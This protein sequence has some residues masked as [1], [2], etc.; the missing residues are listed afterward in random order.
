[1][2][3]QMGELQ[4][5]HTGLE[6]ITRV[7]GCQLNLIAWVDVSEKTPS[8]VLNAAPAPVIEGRRHAL[9]RERD[10]EDKFR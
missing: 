2:V 7:N 5:F 9:K 6:F 8:D 10:V 3:I 4:I 1:M